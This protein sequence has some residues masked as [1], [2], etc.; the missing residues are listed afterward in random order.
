[1]RTSVRLSSLANM[2]PG[3][4]S[5]SFQEPFEIVAS[6]SCSFEL[7]GQLGDSCMSGSQLSAR[8]V[9]LLL[10]LIELDL[11]LFDSTHQLFDLLRQPSTLDSQMTA[12]I[13][14]DVRAILPSLNILMQLAKSSNCSTWHAAFYTR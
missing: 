10:D 13:V 6:L 14:C 8:F 5:H 9:E 11:F 12:L 4:R 1:M 7:V 2:R 3:H